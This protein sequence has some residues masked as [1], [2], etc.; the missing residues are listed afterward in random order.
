MQKSEPSKQL[1]KSSESIMRDDLLH[2]MH[3]GQLV[4]PHDMTA[5]PDNMFD[6]FIWGLDYNI[7]DIVSVVVPGNIK[8]I[9]ER[10]FGNCI[11]LERVILSEGIE[12]IGS[13]AFSGCKK[14]RQVQ[15]PASIRTIDGWAFFKSGLCDPVFSADGKTLVYYPQTWD[16]SEYSVPEGVEEIGSRAFI[17]AKQLTKVIL[18]R[19]LKR[20]RSRAFMECAFTEIV[21]PGNAV[22]ED[23]AFTLFKHE[24]RIIHENHL[25][26]LDERLE[27]C[28]CAG[29]S[30]LHSRH[31]K[32]PQEQYWKTA[33]FVALAEQCAAG[34]VEAMERMGDYFFSRA[35]N[36]DE[37][38]FYQCAA[39]F[40]RMRACLYGSE[41]ARQYLLE[42]C[43]AHP[44][45]YMT[46]PALD[47][48]LTGSAYGNLLNALGFLF[49]KPD[50]LYNLGGV[51][52][53]GVVEVST[54]ESEDPPDEDGFG[55][56][57]Y[58]D[59]WYLDQYL[60]LPHGIGYIHSYSNIDRRYSEQSFQ[61]LHDQVAASSRYGLRTE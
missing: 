38:L 5:I 11:N 7:N 40:W 50:R 47:E 52:K 61:R 54:W 34:S 14:L 8:S 17:D 53:Q 46:S 56:E 26:L 44:N 18:P 48:H 23:G 57:R 6:N 39:Q 51:D 20:I 36:A 59:W 9:G 58:Y 30:F 25:N 41:A 10:A 27:H 15:L 12:C 19:S 24:V 45:A 29:V 2:H 3:N 37:P 55:R 49:F 21:I 22:I 60:T 1:K 43:E 4:I 31:M 33:D 16:R 28:R 32:A 35:E 13:N 42:W